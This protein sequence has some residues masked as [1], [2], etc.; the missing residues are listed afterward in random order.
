MPVA[1]FICLG[2][3]LGSEHVEIE[4]PRLSRRSEIMEE[5]K[6]LREI[7]DHSRVFS[8][9]KVSIE[10]VRGVFALYQSC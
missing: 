7:G 1:L 6:H 5:K 8:D 4:N 3:V 2:R 9:L 10:A